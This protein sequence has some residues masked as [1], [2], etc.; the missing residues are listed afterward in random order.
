MT[1]V[2]ETEIAGKDVGVCTIISYRGHQ[3]SGYDLGW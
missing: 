1:Y 2:Y 3:G